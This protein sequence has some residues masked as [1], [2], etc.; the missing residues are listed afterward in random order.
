[1]VKTPPMSVNSTFLM[2]SENEKFLSKGLE[3]K[4]NHLNEQDRLV[5]EMFTAY[6]FL[7]TNIP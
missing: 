3:E 2:V 6:S 5:W 4:A 1:V 7:L